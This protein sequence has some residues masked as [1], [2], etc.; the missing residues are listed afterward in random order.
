MVWSL[1]IERTSREPSM[2]P[3]SPILLCH[4]SRS[5][6]GIASLR[7]MSAHFFSPLSR[8]DLM[9]IFT[10]DLKS[11]FFERK[12]HFWLTK[13]ECCYNTQTDICCHLRNHQFISEGLICLMCIVFLSFSDELLDP[14]KDAAMAKHQMPKWESY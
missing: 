9:I 4:V 2:C 8:L 1:N 6:I 3:V 13:F 10:I 12:I 11:V 14:T 5:D 7:W